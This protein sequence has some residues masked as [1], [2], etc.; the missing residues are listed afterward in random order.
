[1]VSF[2]NYSC[3]IFSRI[4]CSLKYCF[5]FEWSPDN[6]SPKVEGEG[7][8]VFAT[9]KQTQLSPPRKVVPPVSPS[10]GTSPRSSPSGLDLQRSQSITNKRKQPPSSVTAP[11][12]HKK[13][14]PPPKPQTPLNQPSPKPPRRPSMNKPPPP[15]KQTTPQPPPQTEK[16]RSNSIGSKPPPPKKGSIPLPPPQHEKPR[17]STSGGKSRPP[18]PSHHSTGSSQPSSSKPLPRP[19]Q[20]IHQQPPPPSKVVQRFPL[21]VNAV[22]SPTEKPKV[23]LPPGWIVSWSKSQKRWYFFDTR[24]NKSVWEWPPPGGK[25]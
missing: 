12:A 24:A 14:A 6:F 19:S 3:E 7:E 4:F 20:P 22:Q 18:P 16:R 8:A 10:P 17:R 15:K 2:L 9:G 5:I 1:M 23:T 11:P 21:D 25:M 13:Q